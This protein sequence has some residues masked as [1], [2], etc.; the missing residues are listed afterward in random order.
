MDLQPLVERS[1][2]KEDVFNTIVQHRSFQSIL[3]A[4]AV[5]DVQSVFNALGLNSTRAESSSSAMQLEGVLD[6]L[7]DPKGVHGMSYFCESIVPEVN[8]TTCVGFT[9]PF[10]YEVAIFFRPM[11]FSA[12]IVLATACLFTGGPICLISQASLESC[13]LPMGMTEHT[14]PI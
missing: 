5:R 10:H 8:F 9:K 3:K 4:A 13:H 2:P 6:R 1:N 7:L 12:R 14:K 11:F